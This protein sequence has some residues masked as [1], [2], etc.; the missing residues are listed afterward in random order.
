MGFVGLD[1]EAASQLAMRLEQATQ[2]LRAHAGAV[3]NL[4]AQAGLS[5]HAPDTMIDVAAWA[6]YR[7]RDLRTRIEKIVGAEAMASGSL[8]GGLHFEIR[9]EA[10]D[11]GKHEADKIGDDLEYNFSKKDI[12]EH[13]E[14]LRQYG[15]DPVYAGAF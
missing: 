9:S 15:G 8:P 3:A 4:L 14:D 13:L 7:K 11:A 10:V 5:S 2:D 1:P 12:P 6:D